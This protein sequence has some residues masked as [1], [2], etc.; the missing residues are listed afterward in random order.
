MNPPIVINK[1]AVKKLDGS[2][3]HIN[4]IRDDLL[5]GG[6]KQRALIKF[7]EYYNNCYKNT[8][9]KNYGGPYPVINKGYLIRPKIKDNQIL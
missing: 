6:T 7:I 5:A 4:V 2:I 9:C 1:H 3:I 8:F